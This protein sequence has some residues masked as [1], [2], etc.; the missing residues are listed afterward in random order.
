V[1][2]TTTGI[3][4]ALSQPFT[5]TDDPLTR[6]VTLVKAVHI[7]E[8]R[9]DINILRSRKS[10]GAFSFADPT[11]TGG[12]TQIKA[13]HISELRTALNAVYDANGIAHPRNRASNLY[14][15]RDRCG[16]HVAACRAH[17]RAPKRC[18]GDA[19]N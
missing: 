5:F 8:L 9:N 19:V 3:N 11:L 4:F 14:R 12:T 6:G 15:F 7:T 13:V 1:P 16:F 10:I 18:A 2:A 17:F